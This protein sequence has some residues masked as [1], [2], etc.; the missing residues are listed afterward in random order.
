MKKVL[1]IFVVIM[2]L[3]GCGKND[4]KEVLKK[5]SSKVDG[6][7]TYLM[8]GKLEIYRDDNLYTYDV[9]SSY[10]KDDN[11]R[12]SLTNKTNNHEQIILRNNKGVYVLTPSLGKC[13]KFQ[14]EWPYNNSQIYLLQP[15]VTDLENNSKLKFEKNKNGYIFTAKVNYINDSKLTHQKVYLSKDLILKKVEVLNKDNKVIMKLKVTKFEDNN[16]FDDNY[17][18]TGDSYNNNS[19]IEKDKNNDK[20]IEDSD[21][22]ENEEISE[23]DSKESKK[24]TNTNTVSKEVLYP[25]YVPVDTHLSSQDDVDMNGGFRTILNF[26]GDSPFTIIE[27]SLDD[28]NMKYVNGDPT[29]IDGV[30]GALSEQSVSWISDNKEYYL[31]SKTVTSDEL[32]KIA[33]SL[34]V[35]QV[36]K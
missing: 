35:A 29:L 16:N 28:N 23:N 2:C 18:D 30:I 12:V 34:S 7:D 9:E 4:A 20:K 8:K 10:M 6:Y 32:Y 27:S 26:A 22:E 11:Y 1:F 19:K 14:S 21:D 33:D 36:G 25:M 31:T 24:S 17:F 3:A 13:F 15:I 5:W